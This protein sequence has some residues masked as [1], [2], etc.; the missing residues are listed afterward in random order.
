MWKQSLNVSIGNPMAWGITLP[1]QSIISEPPCLTKTNGY[2]RSCTIKSLKQKWRWWIFWKERDQRAGIINSPHQG[3]KRRKSTALSHE[4]F[5][6]CNLGSLNL[7]L[8]MMNTMACMSTRYYAF[9]YIVRLFC[10]VAN[11]F[12]HVL[13]YWQN[14]KSR[15]SN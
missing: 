13:R 11:I 7:K 1:L 10:V 15:H 8:C 5:Y 6:Q 3:K 2:L 12:F 9:R 14:K 4:G